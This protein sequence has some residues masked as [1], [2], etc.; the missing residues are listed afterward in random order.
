MASRPYPGFF[1]MKELAKIELKY[2]LMILGW[3]SQVRMSD[4]SHSNCLK[5]SW[6]RNLSNSEIR[7]FW[8]VS[9]RVFPMITFEKTIG[10]IFS[11]MEWGHIGTHRPAT[12]ENESDIVVHFGGK[13]Y[14]CQSSILASTLLIQ[15][16][17][18]WNTTVVILPTTKKPRRSFHDNLPGVSK[19]PWVT[20]TTA[21]CQYTCSI[22]FFFLAASPG[23]VA[24]IFFSSISTRC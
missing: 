16:R 24:L 8:V 19:G 17:W 20:L 5:R 12:R 2:L 4:L 9:P 22:M 10:N 21:Y 11:W 13:K 7:R 18:E 3:H 6:T 1:L 15:I 14:V 23:G